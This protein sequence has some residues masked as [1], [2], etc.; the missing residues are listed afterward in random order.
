M[1]RAARAGRR[2]VREAARNVQRVARFEGDLAL[3]HRARV[4][5][6]RRERLALDR[7]LDQRAVDAPGLRAVELE[8][9]RVVRIVVQRETLCARRGEVDVGLDERAQSS[10][11]G[12]AQPLQPPAEKRRVFD[13]QRVAAVEG[14]RDAARIDVQLRAAAGGARPRRGSLDRILV[15]RQGAGVGAHQGEALDVARPDSQGLLDVGQ[16]V[17]RRPPRRLTARD[18][19]RCALE[20]V[21]EEGCLVDGRHQNGEDAVGVR[22]LGCVVG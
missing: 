18:V 19:E 15:R 5:V 3:E 20:V 16:A 14:A 6:G 1:Q 22:R 12:G 10:L 13:Q 17:E 21:G 7:Q 11:Q 9:Q 8:D 4:A 2:G